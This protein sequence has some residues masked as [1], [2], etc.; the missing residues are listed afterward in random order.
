MKVSTPSV[1]CPNPA[2]L[3]P[4]NPLG[5]QR[6]SQCK[7]Q[8]VHRY[9]WAVGE[10]LGRVP[11]G[12]LMGDRYLVAAPHIWLD[13]QPALTPDASATLP[14]ETI[15]YLKLYSYHLHIP[16]VY[17]FCQQGAVKDWVLLLDNVPLNENGQLYPAIANHWEQVTAVRQIYW[18][19]QMLELWT[20]LQRL[21][22]AASLLNPENIRVEGWRIRLRE[23]I[24]DNSANSARSQPS[25]HLA[26]LATLWQGWLN[27]VQMQIMQPL[28]QIY[29]RMRTTVA[30]ESTIAEVTTML[31]QLMLEQAARLPL[32]IKVAGGTTT[33]PQRAHNEDACYPLTV[34]SQ[35]QKHDPLVPNL[36]IICD[37]IG[38]HAGGEVA[39]Q[40]AVRSLQLQILAMLSEVAEQPELTP[41][42]IVIQQ[43]EAVIRVVNNLIAEQNNAQG[44]E[45]RQRMGTTV[46]LALQL[47]QHLT[48]PS[49][50][51]NTHELYLAHVGDSR[52][53]WLTPQHCHLLTLDDDV[54]VRE[55]CMGR[56]LYWEALR[57][58]DAAALTQALGTRD[59]ELLRP[60]VRRFLIEED[61]I[62]LLCSDGL[63]DG[64]R[65][66]KNWKEAT[67]QVM[68]DR[69]SLPE[70]VQYWLN[71][72]NERNGH[73]NASV[74]LMH[75]QIS[76]E[77]PKL[78]EP[79]E[80]PTHETLESELSDSARALLYDQYTESVKVDSPVQEEQPPL[81]KR[82]SS[83]IVLFALG[84]AVLMFSM[85]AIGVT[86]W[87]QLDPNFQ[88]TFERLIPPQNPQEP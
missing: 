55:A 38:G 56:S 16:T 59:G 15:P 73:D 84:I 72:A 5:E 61:G 79:V 28:Q 50:S 35:L 21:G 40:M 41:P 60:T 74:V 62:L 33:G 53:Y 20:P 30:S 14:D 49:G 83:R 67:I 34:D 1:Q 57:R 13:T 2:C 12:T 22:V 7:T 76:P 29:E 27:G 88:R 81:P 54:A 71:L 48:T 80:L 26:D 43:L 6:C 23:L 39:S 19:W 70:A 52:A 31:N 32:K 66:P 9:L 24:P 44:R 45:A 63:S 69:A 85:G 47:P 87:R 64:D 18:L 36:A 82:T 10:T 65:I 78:I 4:E 68:E 8:L 25:P 42:E 75:C 3:F 58:T 77:Y 86:L 11:R 37:G 51:G 17:G 46:V